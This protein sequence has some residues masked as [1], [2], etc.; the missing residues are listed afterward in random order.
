MSYAEEQRRHELTKKELTASDL[1]ALCAE[2]K[3]T[4]SYKNKSKGELIELLVAHGKDEHYAYL[5]K[6][7]IS[8]KINYDALNDETGALSSKEGNDNNINLNLNDDKVVESV[9]II[10][11]KKFVPYS[12]TNTTIPATTIITGSSVKEENNN[13]NNDVKRKKNEKKMKNVYKSNNNKIKKR[14]AASQIQEE[15]IPSAAATT[16]NKKINKDPS[17]KEAKTDA[18]EAEFKTL[19]AHQKERNAEERARRIALGLIN[20]TTY[21]KEEKITEE[22]SSSD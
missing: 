9:I 5:R 3:L 14:K 11:G 13:N 16:T 4:G 18:S 15:G 10:N 21:E 12:A 1:K 2:A 22:I 8:S 7:G 17:K 19:F 6:N 20:N